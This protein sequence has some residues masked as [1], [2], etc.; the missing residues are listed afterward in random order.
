MKRLF[1][2]GFATVGVAL[3]VVAVAGCN[4]LP[5]ASQPAEH[6][7]TVPYAQPDRRQGN[8]QER[9]SERSRGERTRA[10]N[11]PGHF[12]FYLLNLSWS[13]E[14]CLTHSQAAECAAHSGFVLHGL[15]PQNNDGSYPEH[16]SD[17]PGPSNERAYRDILPD[18]RLLEHEWQTH[19][20]CSGLTPDAYFAEARQAKA[21]VAIPS[22][23]QKVFGEL[24][25][26]P[27]S[28]LS[29]F[30]AANPGLSRDSF[31]LSCGNNRL[32]AF[33]VCMTKDLKAA[34]CNR[35]RSCRANVVKV[36]PPGA[37]GDR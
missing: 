33:E 22:G 16:C 12:D 8:R 9:G 24:Q 5:V 13:P 19:G 28:I 36:T 29:E 20:T 23:L 37:T 15:W 27:D 25:L 17:A 35:V 4:S 10:D 14:F 31:A 18:Q 6:P 30:A 32:T 1:R 3:A 11:T 21:S 26:T 34:S 7:A 2:V